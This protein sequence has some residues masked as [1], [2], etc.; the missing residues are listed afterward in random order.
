MT[1]ALPLVRYDAAC[2]AL[3]EARSVDEVKNIRDK[4]VAMAAYARQAKNRDMEA[5]A[6]EIRLRATRRLDQLRQAQKETVGLN[7]GANGSKI[8]G[9]K[10]NPVMDDRPTLASQG[11]DKNLAHQARVLGAMDEAA[12]ERKVA[13]A[14]D[15][16]AR[17]YRRIIR[18]VEIKQKRESF[19]LDTPQ[20]LLPLPDAGRKIFVIR[21]P[22]ERRW[23]L[24]VGPSV[25]PGALKEKEQAA[26]ESAIVKQLQIRQW[27]LQNKIFE[28][29]DELKDLREQVTDIEREVAAEI[30]AAVGPVSSFSE[31]Y[32]FQCD[33]ATDTE[34]AALPKPDEHEHQLVDRL[35]PRGARSA[36]GSRRSNAVIGATTTSC[37]IS[38]SFPARGAGLE[39][40]RRTGWPSCS[41]TSRRTK[42]RARPSITR[43]S[44]DA[45]HDSQG[46]AS[47]C[48]RF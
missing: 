31:T 8:T 6:V 39:R 34:L 21:N 36:K 45:R 16:T 42:S 41:A 38:S 14:R 15:S 46:P 35:L 9:L 43:S 48:Q 23:M 12:F 22:T 2:H 44:T 33:E 24:V 40:A 18:E 5:D 37:R 3:A 17:V 20:E 4:A 30:K 7:R 10:K 19:S 32:E 28:L 11:I 25:A 29:E 47:L 26:R 1:T 13:E 27:I